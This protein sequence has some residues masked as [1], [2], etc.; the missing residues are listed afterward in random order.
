[1]LG[2]HGLCLNHHPVIAFTAHWEHWFI[3]FLQF[4]CFSIATF[5]F[6][7]HCPIHIGSELVAGHQNSTKSNRNGHIIIGQQ[8]QAN[9][10]DRSGSGVSRDWYDRLPMYVNMF[11]FSSG[12]VRDREYECA[13]IVQLALCVFVMYDLFTFHTERA[14]KFVL[15]NEEEESIE[16]RNKKVEKKHRYQKKMFWIVFGVGSH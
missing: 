12:Y 5:L 16:K 13:F 4:I 7:W 11:P 2:P 10:R 8:R 9:P 1:M 15:K 3:F 6:V 14:L